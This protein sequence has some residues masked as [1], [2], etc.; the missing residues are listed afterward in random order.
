MRTYPG[1]SRRRPGDIFLLPSSGG[2]FVLFGRGR[3][4]GVARFELDGGTVRGTWEGVPIE[5]ITG[6]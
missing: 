1:D 3:T 2:G 5:K 4:G 6:G